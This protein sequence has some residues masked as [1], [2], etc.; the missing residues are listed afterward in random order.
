MAAGRSVFLDT[1]VL[2]NFASTASTVW[3][4]AGLRRPAVVPT[5][6]EE[7]E[8][9]RTRGNEFLDEAIRAIGSRLE[10]LEPTTSKD[11]RVIRESLDPGEAE[12]L[13]AAIVYEGTLATD[14]AAARTIAKERG[15]PVTGSIGL[16]VLGIAR[17]K[18]DAEAAARWLDT[19]QSERSYYS[20]VD[21][22]Q[23]CRRPSDV[24]EQ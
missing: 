3:L 23:T 21:G 16:L 10:L 12:S 18:I 13:H 19:W 11:V 24:F 20:P 22:L 1:T 15:V 14:D 4:A 7:L 17:E 5:V 6:R 9:G 8:A 2:S